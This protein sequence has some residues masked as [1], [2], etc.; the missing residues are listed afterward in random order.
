MND[1]TYKERFGHGIMSG[2]A[3]VSE[4][5]LI[6][7]LLDLA[8]LEKQRSTHKSYYQ[9]RGEIFKKGIVKG[10]TLGMFP[11]GIMM[12]SGRGIFYGSSL[13][14]S[15]EFLD[16]N[17][18]NYF[19]T[20][21]TSSIIAGGVEGALTAPFSMMRTRVV[22]ANAENSVARFGLISLLKTTP[23][24][25]IKR[26]GDWG[27]RSTIYYKMIDDY[28][29]NPLI[30]G[31]F[32]GIISSTITTPVDRLLPVLQQ[33]NAPKNIFTWLTNSFKQNGVKTTFAGNYARILHGGTHTFFIF[34]AL[35]LFH[36]QNIIKF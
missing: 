22:Q 2:A 19:D 8:K 4:Q 7:N 24:N 10:M 23:I 5:F 6:G 14:V 1:K 36:Q 34:G 35:H 9:I 13:A 3:A 31:F 27:I 15:K 12:Y 28:E 33:D 26:A 16:K 20:R 18:Y 17:N 11:W 30:S 32:S 25:S 29:I 21:I